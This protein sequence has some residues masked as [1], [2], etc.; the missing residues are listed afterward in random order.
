MKTPPDDAEWIGE[1]MTNFDHSI[2]LDVAAKLKTGNF[3]ADYTAWDFSASV[4]FEDQCYCAKVIQHY[5]HIATI[6]AETPADIM[7]RC[8]DEFGNS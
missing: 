3:V 7:D 6:T 4:W 2:N 8:S 5:S 1:L